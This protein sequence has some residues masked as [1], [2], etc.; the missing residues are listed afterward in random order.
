MTVINTG[1]GYPKGLNQIAID[2]LHRAGGLQ[3]DPVIN[4]TQTA[5][6][7]A[8]TVASGVGTIG[9]FLGDL[10]NINL[11]KGIGLILAG[12]LILIFAAYEFAHMAGVN[13]VP[14]PV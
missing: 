5:V 12:G 4:T 13:A 2:E 9:S 3:N 11:W 6:N 8:G 1:R 14:I 7:A 10:T